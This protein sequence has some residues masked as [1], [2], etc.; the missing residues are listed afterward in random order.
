MQKVQL[1]IKLGIH[2]L[3]FQLC[4]GSTVRTHTFYLSGQQLKIHIHI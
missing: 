1:N 2:K 3:S 4:Q